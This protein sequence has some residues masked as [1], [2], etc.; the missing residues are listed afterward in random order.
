MRIHLELPVK[1]DYLD[2][3]RYYTVN[4]LVSLIWGKL[5][6]DYVERTEI[7]LLN[8]G[9]DLLHL[10]GTD[11][12]S[13]HGIQDVG[14]LEN[15]QLA[16]FIAHQLIMSSLSQG[17]HVTLWRKLRGG[18]PLVVEPIPPGEPPGE[19]KL[20]S[21]SPQKI[22]RPSL[23]PPSCPLNLKLNFFLTFVQYY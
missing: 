4:E 10:T 7:R 19:E 15:K 6:H 11:T 13:S 5:G 8:Q 9:R 3:E 1:Q 21:I 18:S 2:V 17:S 14:S 20:A 23:Y 12:L 22:P 16:L